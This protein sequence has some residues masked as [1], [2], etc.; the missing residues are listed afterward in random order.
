MEQ[1]NQS[2]GCC[3]LL[4]LRPG[5]ISVQPDQPLA[6]SCGLANGRAMARAGT[7]AQGWPRDRDRGPASAPLLKRLC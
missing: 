6:A 4:P 3:S 7:T 5:A 1:F 2:V